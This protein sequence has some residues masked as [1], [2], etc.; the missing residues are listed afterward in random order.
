MYTMIVHCLLSSGDEIW[1]LAER[2]LAHEQ[3]GCYDTENLISLES[4][5]IVRC[6][7]SIEGEK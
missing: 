4:V 2:W 5:R 3:L 6:K 7:M 1:S